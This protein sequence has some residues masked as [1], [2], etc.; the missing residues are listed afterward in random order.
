MSRVGMVFGVWLPLSGGIQQADAGAGLLEVVVVD[1]A[2]PCRQFVGRAGVDADD[3][4]AARMDEG[5]RDA[6]VAPVELGGVGL[7]PAVRARTAG[8]AAVGQ[9]EEVQHGRACLVPEADR[10]LVARDRDSGG[11]VK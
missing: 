4:V 7:R 1:I 10:E 11:G 3:V 5:V 9:R 8:T 2:P 6:V